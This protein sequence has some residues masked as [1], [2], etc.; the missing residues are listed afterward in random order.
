MIDGE[1]SGYMPY[2]PSLEETFATIFPICRH[3]NETFRRYYDG[4]EDNDRAAFYS[5]P[6]L[7]AAQGQQDVVR[8]WRQAWFPLRKPLETGPPSLCAF[9]DQR[10]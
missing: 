10:K 3:R 8:E 6:C 5:V 1:H 9:T 7:G 2:A 4:A